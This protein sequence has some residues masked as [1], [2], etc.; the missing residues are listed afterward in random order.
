MTYILTDTIILYSRFFKRNSKAM[1][2]SAAGKRK[3]TRKWSRTIFI[4]E[5]D[6]DSI[7]GPY[8]NCSDLLS[9]V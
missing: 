9:L 2:E 1:A 5:R 4:T 7:H 3:R 8:S 6:I